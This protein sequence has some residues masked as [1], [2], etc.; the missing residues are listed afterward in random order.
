M[1]KTMCS[2]AKWGGQAR[3]TQQRNGPE[4]EFEHSLTHL[5][6]KEHHYGLA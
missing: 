6:K 5:A 3:V 1:M 2:T 4:P